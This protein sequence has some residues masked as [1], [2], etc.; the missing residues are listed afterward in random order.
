MLCVLQVFAYFTLRLFWPKTVPFA[1][2]SKFFVKV[3]HQ[4]WS[5]IEF[6]NFQIVAHGFLGC[7]FLEK[8]RIFHF[9]QFLMHQKKKKKKKKWVF[10]NSWTCYLW[11]H[12]LVHF[13]NIYIWLQALSNKLCR[14]K[15]QAKYEIFAVFVFLPFLAPL[16]KQ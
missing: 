12:F 8:Y 4:T 5:A 10:C 6:E 14:F 3:R 1:N 11:T 16:E 15:N 9:G 2:H 7:Q 13:Q